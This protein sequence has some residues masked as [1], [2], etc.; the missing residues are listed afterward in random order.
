MASGY[1]TFTSTPGTV[2]LRAATSALVSGHV[3]DVG[4]VAEPGV[5]ARHQHAVLR[6]VQVGLERIGARVGRGFS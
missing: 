6:E 3:G 1:V 2:R 4:V 5:V